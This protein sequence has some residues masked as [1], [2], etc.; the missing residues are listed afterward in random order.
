MRRR[1]SGRGPLS[2]QGVVEFAFVSIVVLL[3]SVGII[4]LGR[5]VYQ[6]QMLTNAVREAARAGSLAP[7]NSAAM[8]A[9]GQRTSPTLGLT[10]S[11]FTVTCSNWDDSNSVYTGYSTANCSS[12]RSRDYLKVC[13]NYT[14]G[15]TAPRLIGWKTVS[16]NECNVTTIQHH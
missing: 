13:A 7:S 14:F 16:M 3:L 15:L 1:H 11:N 6:R 2:G 12:S 4:D 10:T 8:A 9:A 5:G